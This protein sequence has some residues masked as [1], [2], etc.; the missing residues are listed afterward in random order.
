MAINFAVNYLA[1]VV[2]AIAAV[3]IGIVY[4]GLAGLGDRLARMSGMTPRSGPPSPMQFAI[5]IAVGL[6]NA[7]VLGLL[8][9]NLGASSIADG[10]VLGVLVWLGFQATVKAAQVAFERRSW[11]TWVLTGAHDVLIQVVM[12]TIVS[13]WR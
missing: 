10:I 13:V 7:W 6:V 9:L 8:S 5:G 11:N 12:A 3:L 1:V 4:Y 2:A